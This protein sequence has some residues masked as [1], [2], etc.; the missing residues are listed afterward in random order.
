MGG[1][2]GEYGC[3]Y[4]TYFGAYKVHMPITFIMTG[5]YKANMGV[6]KVYIGCIW[7]YISCIWVY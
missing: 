7:L 1:I 3:V 5:V 2:E 4:T 6:Y